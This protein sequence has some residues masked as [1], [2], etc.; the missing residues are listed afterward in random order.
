MIIMEEAEIKVANQEVTMTA[1]MPETEGA[2]E[3]VITMIT[4]IVVHLHQDQDRLGIH[5]ITSAPILI[6]EVTGVM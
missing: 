6:T 4:S 3:E 5:I 2:V 1:T